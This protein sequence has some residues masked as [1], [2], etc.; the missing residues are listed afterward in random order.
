MVIQGNKFSRSLEEINLI[1]CQ[2]YNDWRIGYLYILFDMNPEVTEELLHYF[3][4]IIII[5]TGTASSFI[6]SLNNFFPIW[7]ALK[8]GYPIS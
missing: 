6:K 5:S 8:R 2:P 4:I 7:L 1:R 3:I